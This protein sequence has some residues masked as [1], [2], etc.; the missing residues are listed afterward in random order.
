M[1]KKNFNKG[2]I[3]QFSTNRH[4]AVS[5]ISSIDISGVD[6]TFIFFILVKMKGHVIIY[7]MLK[8]EDKKDNGTYIAMVLEEEHINRLLTMMVECTGGKVNLL[9]NTYY[10]RAFEEFNKLHDGLHFNGAT[11]TEYDARNKLRER[12]NENII[13]SNMKPLEKIDALLN[14]REIER[15]RYFLI[16]NYK[17]FRI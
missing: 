17:I 16:K 7:E 4:T 12:Y 9:R 10:E 14:H 6:V 2:I 8:C 11:V 5:H 15:E 1:K 3:I 13:S